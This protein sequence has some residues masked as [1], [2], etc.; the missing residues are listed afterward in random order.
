MLSAIIIGIICGLL[1]TQL[2]NPYIY[3]RLYEKVT[4]QSDIIIKSHNHVSRVHKFVRR[5]II[6]FLIGAIAL[7]C[8]FYFG[9]IDRTFFAIVAVLW[10][11]G[12]ILFVNTI[13]C[14]DD[15]NS[16]GADNVFLSC[17]L[18]LGI[19]FFVVSIAFNIAGPIYNFGHQQE[20][21]TILKEHEIPVSSIDTI[22]NL[23]EKEIISGYSLGTPVNRDGKTIVPLIRQS[24]NVDYVGY[25]VID[26]NSEP[27]I[28]EKPMR[29]TPY[30]ISSNNVGMIARRIMPSAIFF[31]NWSLQ[32]SPEEDVWFVIVFG[33]HEFLRAGRNIQGL[34][35]I[36][37][38]NGEY[39]ITS[40]SEHPDWVDGIS[41]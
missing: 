9:G 32:I 23:K 37:A 24:G 15:F 2:I 34:F 19:V 10:M 6:C 13:F 8:W 20:A 38:E 21:T 33:E 30:H 39:F 7:T 22:A 36:N 40:I 1:C 31:G 18:I 17:G 14:D 16:R 41:E 28:V 11:P 35:L 5:Q 4:N 12:V 3:I 27:S 26:E 25:V 29:Y